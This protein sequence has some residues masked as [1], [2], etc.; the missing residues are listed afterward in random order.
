MA[1]GDQVVVSLP[2]ANRDPSLVDSPDSFDVER[3]PTSHVAF[4]HGVH[5]CIGAPLARMEMR[6]ALSALF[7][8]FPNLRL[9]NDPKDISFRR[10]TA[11]H[12]VEELVLTW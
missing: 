7:E 9:A 2:M 4:G 5:H 1:V 6:V 12:G 10:L 11:V 8:S 3:K